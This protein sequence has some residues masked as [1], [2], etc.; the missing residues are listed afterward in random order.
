MAGAKCVSVKSNVTVK[1]IDDKKAADAVPD[2][3][4]DTISKAINKTDDL[5]YDKRCADGWVITVSGTVKLIDPDDPKLAMNFSISCVALFG[6]DS[7]NASAKRTISINPKKKLVD[8]VTSLI[9][10][11]L[12]DYTSK[13]VIPAM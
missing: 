6:A 5:T 10:D 2:Q 1:D 13:Q 7:V 8:E 4:V 11:F 3:I 12:S 9:D